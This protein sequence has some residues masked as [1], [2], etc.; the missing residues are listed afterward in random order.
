MVSACALTMFQGICFLSGILKSLRAFQNPFFTSGDAR[1]NDRI[2]GKRL[3]TVVALSRE[4]GTPERPQ[5]LRCTKA[6]KVISA[7]YGQ[8]AAEAI[9]NRLYAKK[10][11]ARMK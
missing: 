10:D 4:K 8:S 11:T 2:R 9:L 3:L 5:T 7:E 1:E 6:I